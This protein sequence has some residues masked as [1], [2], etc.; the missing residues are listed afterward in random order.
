MT[1]LNSRLKSAAS[2]FAVVASLTAIGA[3]APSATAEI[4]REITCDSPAGLFSTGHDGAGGKLSPGTIDP[5]WEFAPGRTAIDSAGAAA[6]AFAPSLA[7][8]A[9]AFGPI[10]V[11]ANRP[12]TWVQSPFANADWIGARPSQ[13]D[14][15]LYYRL[16]FTLADSVDPRDFALRVTGSWDDTLSDVFIN[17]TSLH[18]QGLITYGTHGNFQ[19]LHNLPAFDDYWVAGRNE[20][21]F[22]VHNSISFQGTQT[23]GG[24][25]IQA[26]PDA[27]CNTR[28]DISKSGPSTASINDQ[29]SYDVVVTNTGS[30]SAANFS[31][32][33]SAQN[34]GEI[35]FLGWTCTASGGGPCP[36][37]SGTGSLN[38]T[39][40][41]LPR[42]VS[43][44]SMPSLRECWSAR[45]LR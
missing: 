10:G 45:P 42:Q 35:E 12:A 5:S 31:V 36:E 11:P 44:S 8:D 20:M 28:L 33:D 29:I 9:L 32:V 25:M 30:T 24:L 39:V 3:L 2:A 4:A 43:R 1:H 19:S 14:R 40:P 16:V 26:Q 23:A 13:S 6:Y 37:A 38:T 34:A 21:V 17:G 7:S 22:A 15:Y 27:L 41:S 18:D